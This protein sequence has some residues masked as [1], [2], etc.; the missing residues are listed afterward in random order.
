MIVWN[1]S[2]ESIWEMTP[3]QLF[4]WVTLGLDREK[5]E[6]AFRLLDAR[7]AAHSEGSEIQRTLKEL[8][9]S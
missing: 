1:H 6:R 8:T 5:I 9:G 7:H 3:R 2:V 4:A